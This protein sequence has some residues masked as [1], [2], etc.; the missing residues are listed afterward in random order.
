MLDRKNCLF[1]LFTAR[2]CSILY[3]HEHPSVADTG[4][5]R[6]M[7]DGRWDKRSFS[8]IVRRSVNGKGHPIPKG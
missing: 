4:E 6:S 3:S 1:T 7:D 2:L 5:S 8:C